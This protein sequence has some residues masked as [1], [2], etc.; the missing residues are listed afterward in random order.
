VTSVAA[1]GTELSALAVIALWS[2][3]RP[4]LLV[5]VALGVAAALPWLLRRQAPAAGGG[6]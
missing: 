4:A 6:S 2:L 3:G 1:L 5:V